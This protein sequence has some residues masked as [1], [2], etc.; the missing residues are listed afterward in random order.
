MLEKE[1]SKAIR[2]KK[3]TQADFDQILNADS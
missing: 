2:V 3:Y 1:V